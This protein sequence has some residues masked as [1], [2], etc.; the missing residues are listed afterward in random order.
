M[1]IQK[2]GIVGCGLMGSSIAVV[3]AIS[4]YEVLVSD[5]NQQIL[6]K[7][8][9]KAKRVLERMASEGQIEGVKSVTQRITGTTDLAQYSQCHIVIEA[10]V[11]KIEPKKVL[12][13]KLDKICRADA[14]LATNTST[15]SVT[16]MAA[17]TTRMEKV[18]GLHFIAPAYM[19]PVLEIM[20]TIATSDATIKAA[21]KFGESLGMDVFVTRDYPGFVINNIQIPMLLQ[22]VRVL[23]KNLATKEEIDLVMTKGMGHRIGP[24]ALLD[25]VGLDTVL[26]MAEEIYQQTKDMTWAAPLLLRKMVAAGWFGRKTKKGFYDY[27]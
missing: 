17:A 18:L 15:L 11:E 20:K 8:L 1:E 3:C 24:L 10:I 13:Q 25:Y 7:G 21:R 5:L 14:L 2:I 9:A 22:A 27:A 16:D 23:E 19:F 6:D 12:F 26:Y 4:G